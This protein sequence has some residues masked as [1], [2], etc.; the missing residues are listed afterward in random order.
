VCGFRKEVGQVA[1]IDL[2]LT[3]FAESEE[4]ETPSVEFSGDAGD[5]FGSFGRED[6]LRH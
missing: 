3:D 1:V 4:F 2:L 6:V 5:E